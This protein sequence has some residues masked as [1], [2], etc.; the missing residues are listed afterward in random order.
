[1]PPSL[2]V[3]ILFFAGVR[4]CEFCRGDR[5]TKYDLRWKVALGLEMEE[6]PIQKSALQEFQ[7]RLV[8]HEQGEA[9]LKKSVDEAR[10]AGYVTTPKD[11]SGAGHDAD[12]GQRSGEGTYNLLADGIEN[13][14]AGWRRW[15][16]T[17]RQ[18]A[19]KEGL[20]VILAAALK[21]EAAIDWDDK[22]QRNQLLTQIVQDGQATAELGRAGPARVPRT[23]AKRFKPTRLCW[24]D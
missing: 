4:G 6:V 10:R 16:E 9:L 22:A 2:A 18:L 24:S 11:S 20:H 7:A 23:W 19:E 13:W 15:P 8:L 14:R 17:D 1:V 21:G 5:A 3:S 12:V